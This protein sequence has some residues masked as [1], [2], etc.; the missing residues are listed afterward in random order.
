MKHILHIILTAFIIS[1][2]TSCYSIAQPDTSENKTSPQ[3]P[4][5]SFDIGTG[6]FKTN[7]YSTNIISYPDSV[8]IPYCWKIMYS[9]NNKWKIGFGK[10]RIA[11]I[12]RMSS[13][14]SNRYYI[15]EEF[16]SSEYFPVNT[17]YFSFGISIET[18]KYT[19]GY[20]LKPELIAVLNVRTDMH[21]YAYPAYR[22]GLSRNIRNNDSPY[23]NSFFSFVLSARIDLIT[24]GKTIDLKTNKDH[25][26]FS[27]AYIFSSVKEKHP[28]SSSLYNNDLSIL[29]K[30]AL[31][32]RGPSIS[33]CLTSR[34]C[35]INEIDLGYNVFYDERN[36]DY[37]SPEYSIK[38]TNNIIHY[39][40]KVGQLKNNLPSYISRICYPYFGI[41][42]LYISNQVSTKENYF[43]DLA[44]YTRS[45]T[46]YFYNS[47]SFSLLIPLGIRSDIANLFF[48]IGFNID[49]LSFVNGNYEYS[50]QTSNSLGEDVVINDS[51]RFKKLMLINDLCKMKV[52]YTSTVI[53]IGYK[54]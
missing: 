1:I 25:F 40:Y 5:L 3:K 34:M 7:T 12:D 47:H 11:F 53:K 43:I 45:Y 19:F 50:Y 51:Q 32:Y 46:N 16:I 36:G 39:K 18:G 10:Q 9:F 27:L 22:I 26:G 31:R 54:F 6:V 17:R 52:F 2:I 42:L 35:N 20:F 23:I 41:M 29:Y 38:H 8:Y 49:L 15:N 28:Y 48:D 33:F 44:P 14:Y 4:Y 21:L 37:I 30:N 24:S 13:G